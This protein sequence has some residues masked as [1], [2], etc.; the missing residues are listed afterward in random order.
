MYKR[1]RDSIRTRLFGTG[2]TQFL[3]PAWNQH[4]SIMPSA[5]L[6]QMEEIPSPTAPAMSWGGKEQPPC[7]SHVLP[8]A[9]VKITPVLARTRTLLLQAKYIQNISLSVIFFCIVCIK[10]SH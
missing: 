5:T 10:S 4:Y 3:P 2:T 9:T 7:P 6:I 1:S 8:F